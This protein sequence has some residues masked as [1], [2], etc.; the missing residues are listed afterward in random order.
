MR[1]EQKIFDD[2]ATLCASPGYAHAIAYFSFRDHVVGYGDT[3]K[4]ADYAKLFSFERLIRT[5]ISTL[6]GLMVRA[7]RDLTIPDTKTLESYI[8]RTETL[9]RELHDA[10]DEPAKAELKEA[11]AEPGKAQQFNPFAKAE[12]GCP[13]HC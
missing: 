8:K 12:G 11:F 3:L 4:G 13:D 9:L 10:L 6:I 1:S 2:L 5:E 7:P